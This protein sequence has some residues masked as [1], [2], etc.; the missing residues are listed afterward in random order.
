[1]RRGGDKIGYAK[2]RHEKIGF[3]HKIKWFESIE[4]KLRKIEFRLD[5]DSIRFW[6]SGICPQ[7]NS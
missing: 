1:M 5:L 2:K 4:V 7:F 3:D 6:N